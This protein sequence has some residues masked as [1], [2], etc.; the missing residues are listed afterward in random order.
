[1]VVSGLPNITPIFI[2]IWLMKMTRVFERLMLAVSLR[3]AWLIRRAWSPTCESPISPSSSAFGVSAATESMTTTSTA[4]ERTTMSAI[5]SACSPVS[6][7]ETSN[8]STSTPI[9][10]AYCGSSA[11]SASMNAAVPPLRWVRATTS[12][13]RV[14]LPEASGP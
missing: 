14:V 2:R 6:G 11:C 13:V 10:S 3:N 12:R 9:F 7:W 8:S 1:M 5:S 4:P